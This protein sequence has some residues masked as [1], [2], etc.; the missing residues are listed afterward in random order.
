[1]ELPGVELFTA[2]D[3][4]EA[5]EVLE[6]NAVDLVVTDV[7]MPRMD[8]MT[9]VAEMISRGIQLPVIMVTAFGNHRVE[10][11]A[12]QHGVLAVTDKPIDFDHLVDLCRNTLRSLSRGSLG[13]ITLAGLLQL[14]EMERR[15]CT[16]RAFCSDHSGQVHV[17][18]GRIVGSEQDEV[19][20]KAA[21]G[22]ILSWAE[23]VLDLRPLRPSKR[24][25]DPISLQAALI[26]AARQE[27]E[28]YHHDATA[29]DSEL[30]GFDFEE[31]GS[32]LLTLP[33]ADRVLDT[34]QPDEPKEE[35]IAMATIEQAINAAMSIPGTIAVALADHD[36]GM[37]LGSK[38]N[39]FA[40]EVAA[41][42]NTEVIRAKLRV[43]ND[44]GLEGGITD[45]LITLDNQ[46]HLIMPLSKGTL[47][48]YLALDRK[49]ANLA[50]A[51]HKLTEIGKG[52]V[53]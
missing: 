44:L 9:L 5:L 42:G 18:Q 31:L 17:D 20:G 43:M 53:V 26:D 8:G 35:R 52:L 33:A 2:N 50:L 41:A 10:S 3:G 23:P 6:D 48:L 19:S 32:G 22:R 16:V 39:N 15:S 40:I 30:G 49:N 51:R 11:N 13:G 45:M 46:Y 25:G 28:R 36:S 29:T 14:L 27:D 4:I 1:M 37:C 21:L 12:R 7:N 47:F 24:G 38:A 34:Q